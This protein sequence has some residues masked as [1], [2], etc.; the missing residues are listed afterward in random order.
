MSNLCKQFDTAFR[1]AEQQISDSIVSKKANLGRNAYWGHVPHA[2]DFPLH[3]GTSIKQIRLSRIGFG[4]MSVGWRQVQDDGCFTNVCEAPERPTFA[5]GSTESFYSLEEFGFQSPE[6]CLRVL[7]FRQMGE[8]ELAKIEEHLRVQAQFFW[9]EYYRSR[10][11]HTVEKKIVAQVPEGSID[12]NGVCESL[13]YSCAPNIRTMEGF[14]FSHRSPTGPDVTATTYPIDER[15]VHVNVPV[16][17]I[18]TISE[19]SV[20]LIEQPSIEMELDDANRPLLDEGIPFF[21]VIVPD[22]KIS[23]RLAHLER[24]QENQCLNTVIYNGKDLSLKY[25]IKRIFRDMFSL[26]YDL[27]GMKFYP[28]VVYNQDLDPYDPSDPATWP[29]FVRVFAYINVRNP[30]GTVGAIPNP[31]FM[32]APFGITTIFSPKVMRSRS[33]PEAVSVGGAR[34]GDQARRFNGEVRWVN[35]YD[36]VCNPHREKGHWELDF[37]AAIEPDEPENGAAFFHRLNHTVA[38]SGGDCRIPILPCTNSD[39][40]NFCYNTIV[41]G[42]ADLG[43]SAGTRGANIL[44][45]SS[46]GVSDWL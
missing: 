5:H 15:Y 1:A 45:N 31:Y 23:N 19:L 20:D 8:R 2:G 30:N 34:V 28:D 13:V 41:A 21:D 26:R 24:L 7:R 6:I 29:R 37:G 27:H 33:I 36:K 14:K 16:S 35:E 25:G 11:I 12:G 32:R 4:D 38:L 39:L 40:S 18:P 3:S 44:D 9:N 17:E 42:E 22:A 43:V 46:N 10:Y